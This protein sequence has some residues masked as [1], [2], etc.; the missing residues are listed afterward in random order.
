[1]KPYQLPI[2][3]IALLCIA[4]GVSANTGA[5]ETFKQGLKLEQELKIFEARDTFREAIAMDPLTPGYLDHYGWFLHYHGFSEEVVAVFKKTLPLAED[6]QS[7]TEGLAWNLKVIGQQNPSSTKTAPVPEDSYLEKIRLLRLEISESPNPAPLQ[8]KL[9]YIYSDHNK[10]DNAIQTA[11]DLRSRNAL[12]KLTQLQLARVLFWNGNKHQSEIEYRKLIKG[13]PNSAFL[14]YELAGILDANG[15]LDEALK[16]LEK[17]LSIYPDAPLVK[18]RLAEV[19]AQLGRGNE[20]LNVASSIDTAEYSRLTGLLARARA[21]HFSGQLKDAQEAYQVVINEYPYNSDALWGMTETSIYTGRLKSARAAIAKWEESGPDPR[22]EKQKELLA[23]SSSTILETQAEYYSNS[24]DFTR[25]IYGIDYSFNA[26]ADLQLRTG[27]SHSDFAQIG[28]EDAT[29]ETLFVQGKQPVSEQVQFSGRLEVNEYDNNNT[30]ING[31]IAIQFHHLN[32]F[33]SEIK[34]RHFDTIDTVLS[35]NNILN[36]YV[37]TIGSLWLDIQSD[38]YSLYLLYNPHPRVSLAGEF[39]H[40]EYSD[41]NTKHSLWL[42]AGYQIRYKP[43]IRV[44]YNYFYLDFKNP[45]DIFTQGSQSESAYW[46]PINFDTHTLRLEYSDDYNKRLSY[47]GKTALSYSPKSQGTSMTLSIFGSYKIRNRVS[48]RVDA[49]W[50]DSN[51][52]IDR[53]GSETGPWWANSYNI[54]L[55]YRF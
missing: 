19:L 29:R 41:G 42:E 34:Y 23:L 13:S 40:G 48:L 54:S 10:F 53:A 31:N 49:R 32:T 4:Y 15:K 22:R 5:Y 8:K 25:E 11:E 45:A 55:Q 21:L 24:S 17:S 27:Y 50:F 46:D 33:I 39:I 35:F 44:A 18:K 1:M 36:S 14:H 6:K 43:D 12:D 52:G 3:L 9:F 2:I 37:V 7:I 47:G 51:K 26:G 16:T 20:A 28:F 38:D 30:N